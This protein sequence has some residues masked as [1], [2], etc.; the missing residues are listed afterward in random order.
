MTQTNVITE[1]LHCQNIQQIELAGASLIKKNQSDALLNGYLDRCLGATD[2]NA[3]LQSITGWYFE[4]GY[5]SSRAY[6]APQDLTTGTLVIQVVEGS[7]EGIDVEGLSPRVLQQLFQ[8]LRG[9]NMLLRSRREHALARP[10]AHVPSE[11]K[12]ERP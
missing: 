6:L 8:Q 4:R 7:I 11:G 2:I 12:A 5:I 10:P 9:E 1:R 3:V